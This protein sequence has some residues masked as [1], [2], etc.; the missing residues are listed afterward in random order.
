MGDLHPAMY[1]KSFNY[2]YDFDLNIH[3][4]TM[5]GNISIN[6]LENAY[7]VKNNQIKRIDALN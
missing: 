7:Q 1:R 6:N 4:F 5:K 3:I 2:Y